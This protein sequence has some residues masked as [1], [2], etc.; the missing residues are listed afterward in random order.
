MKTQ[1]GACC[2][3]FE[4]CQQLLTALKT[5]SQVLSSKPFTAYLP[6]TP[7]SSH[8]SVP[9]DFC[10]AV[11]PPLSQLFLQGSP[12]ASTA[13]PQELS[14]A[15]FLKE[16]CCGPPEGHPHSVVTAAL[17]DLSR[18]DLLN[19][20]TSPHWTVSFTGHSFIPS[21]PC[22]GPHVLPGPH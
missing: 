5:E 12:V 21:V 3:L 20:I 17:P 1:V 8:A 13:C 22:P 14:P 15:A 19:V 9:Q 10:P 16:S 4:T 6:P 7:A 2:S 18:P 11:Q